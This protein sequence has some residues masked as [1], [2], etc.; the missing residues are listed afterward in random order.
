MSRTAYLKFKKD[1][2][3][4]RKEAMDAQCYECNGYSVEKKDDCLGVSCPLYGWST[5]GKSRGIKIHS[6]PGGG[7]KKGKRMGGR[8]QI[9]KPEMGVS[10]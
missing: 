7:F 2:G 10:A 6:H 4:T 5:W 3:L 9:Q 1:E 8:S